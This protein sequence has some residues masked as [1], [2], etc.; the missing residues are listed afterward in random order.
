MGIWNSIALPLSQTH[1]QSIRHFI[2]NKKIFYLSFYNRL[3]S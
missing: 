3:G 1:L 2:K